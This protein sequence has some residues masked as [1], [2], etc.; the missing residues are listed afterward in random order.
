MGHF[1][2]LVLAVLLSPDAPR[3]TVLLLMGTVSYWRFGAAT[4]FTRASMV[5]HWSLNNAVFWSGVFFAFSAIEAVS[6][7]GDEIQ[8]PRKAIPWALLV[9]GCI[10][11]IGYIGGTA[12]LMV[13]LPPETV[14]G[15]DGFVNGIRMLS[16]KLGVG[17]LLAPM[18]LL[19]GLNAVGGAAGNL[20]SSARLPF[21]AG[22]DRY[23]PSAF[24]SI[25]PRF[26]TPWVAIGVY[27]FAGIVVAL[28]GQAGTTVR[29]AYDVL[30][31]MGVIALFLPYLFL[32]SAMIRLQNKPAGPQVRRVPGGRPVA[33]ALASLGLISTA[34]TIVL[35]VIPG[36]DEANKPLAVAKVL[37]ATS[38]LI[39]IGVVVFFAETRRTRAKLQRALEKSPRQ[40]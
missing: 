15:P 21:V 13:A 19:V 32:F 38:V 36:S 9:A 3:V 39:G 10:L 18:A 34:V 28:L 40:T 8:N 17:W 12:A 30:V 11:A 14:G 7:M 6:A 31:S 16:E 20:S 2:V 4:H 1:A 5:P 26:R 25:H 24:G 37:G 33:I 29:G 27:G 35:S 23:L 22:V